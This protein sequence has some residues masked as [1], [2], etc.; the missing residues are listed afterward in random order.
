MPIRA[1]RSSCARTGSRGNEELQAYFTAACRL[2]V[3][4]HGKK[5]IG[6]DEILSK[7]MPHN[8]LVQSWRGQKALADTA[9]QGVGGILSNGYYLDLGYSAAHHYAVDPLGERRGGS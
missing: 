3:E 4:K 1:S 2:L 5:M 7:D 8:I 9:R 6:W